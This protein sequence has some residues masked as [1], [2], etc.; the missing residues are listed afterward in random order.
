M[1]GPAV[2]TPEWE[3]EIQAWAEKVAATLPPFTDE[4]AAAVAAT[5]AAVEHAHAAGTQPVERAA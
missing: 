1:I 4:E 3:A 5:I 2:G